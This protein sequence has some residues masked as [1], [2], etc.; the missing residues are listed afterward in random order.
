MLIIF[1]PQLI[2]KYA[3]N[4]GLNP[5]DPLKAI[6]LARPFQMFQARQLVKDICKK[7]EKSDK[8][9]LIV[10]TNLSDIFFDPAI[11]TIPNPGKSSYEL[12][13][14]SLEK[15]QKLAL[16]DNIIIFAENKEKYPL[17]LI[18]KFHLRFKRYKDI[19]FNEI[20]SHS[21]QV[22]QKAKSLSNHFSKVEN[23]SVTLI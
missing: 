7:I 18:A 4:R 1:S 13:R 14:N 21:I 10:I 22:K 9:H 20:V 15:L 6:K 5:D 16:Q 11:N 2:N 8:K 3:T 19:W 17:P 23:S 12:F